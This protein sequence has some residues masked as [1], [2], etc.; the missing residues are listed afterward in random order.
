MAGWLL[1]LQLEL[2]LLLPLG[3]LQCAN[4]AAITA[5]CGGPHSQ[6]L[7]VL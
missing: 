4:T 1:R 2:L 6:L 3:L 7:V 5:A